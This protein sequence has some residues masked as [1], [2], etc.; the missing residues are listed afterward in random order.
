MY[1]A[2]R[3]TPGRSWHLWLVGIIG[4][5]WSS[6]GLVSFILTQLKV[7]AVMSRF[8][9]QQRAY[10]ESFPLWTVAFWAI[11]VFGGVVGCVLLLSKK[12][13]AVPVLLA[14]AIG[15]VLYSLGGLLLLGG[16]QVMRDTDGVGLT[17]V[18][19]VI[20]ALL[21]LYAAAMSK[22]GVLR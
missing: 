21:A 22:K 19:G 16:L 7:E 2:Q 11:G 4:L 20:A 12:R 9:P 3:T 15:T 13:L 6:M 5:L 18:P 1:V 14:S 17:F 10:F 8:P